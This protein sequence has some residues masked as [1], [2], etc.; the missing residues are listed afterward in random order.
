M[1]SVS[2]LHMPEDM[3]P[4]NFHEEILFWGI[5][6]RLKIEYEKKIK[7]RKMGILNAFHR[8]IIKYR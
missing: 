7:I 6:K 4:V 5:G 3:C 2:K 8:S 1:K